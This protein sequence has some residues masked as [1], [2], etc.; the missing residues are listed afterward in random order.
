MIM[1]DKFLPWIVSIVDIFIVAI[2]LYWV[3]K[4]MRGTKAVR[5]L[6]GLAVVMIVYFLSGRLGFMTLHWILSNFLGS[7]V[8]LIIVVFQQD[9]RRALGQMG[10]A[11]SS[12]GSSLGTGYIEEVSKSV[13]AMSESRTG[14]IIVIERS[15]DLS[16]Y[17]DTGVRV[18]AD[19]S[20]ELLMSIFNK[21]SPM[22]DGAVIVSRGRISRAGC[23]LPLTEKDV[24]W[25]V[26]TR[27]RAA[28]GMSEETD[29][30]I[31]VVS[32]KSGAIS[33]VVEEKVSTDIAPGALLGKLSSFFS[34]EDK[35]GFIPW[36]LRL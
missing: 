1:I 20:R 28:I 19:V 16:D 18:D 25:G 27:H 6:Y 11:F 14:A 29:A 24:A 13:A 31:V 3:M 9:I 21:N 23:I 33:V 26:G 35:G 5:M 34:A 22:H 2:V 17:F 32:E 8:I 30:F 7:I 15:V 36:R 4:L 10:Q 12:R